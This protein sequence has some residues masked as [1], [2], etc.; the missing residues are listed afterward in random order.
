MPRVKN[1][2]PIAVHIASGGDARIRRGGTVISLDGVSSGSFQVTGGTGYRVVLNNSTTTGIQLLLGY[3]SPVTPAN[4]SLICQDG[5]HLADDVPEGATVYFS[6]LDPME[7]L[8]MQ[9]GESDYLY[10]S[11]YG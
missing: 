11:I 6:I 4:A 2:L 10:V 8:P 9:G 3:T 7:L 5:S 1:D